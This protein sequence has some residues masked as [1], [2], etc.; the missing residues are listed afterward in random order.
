MS[1]REKTTVGEV[2]YGFDFLSPD[3]SR[4]SGTRQPG[5][6][7]HI[8]CG[9][10]SAP[11]TNEA[12]YST[13]NPRALILQTADFS[14]AVSRRLREKGTVDLSLVSF[15]ES[16][17]HQPERPTRLSPVE[18]GL[19]KSTEHPISEELGSRVSDQTASMAN[20]ITK[21]PL[22]RLEA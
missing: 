22:V 10:E 15:V 14:Y 7:H 16:K 21:P 12:P 11:T 9:E 6:H 19:R 20:C 1:M 4:F 5:L 2:R 8:T 17:E 3:A 13:H 18:T